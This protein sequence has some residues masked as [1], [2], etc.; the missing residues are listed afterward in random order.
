MYKCQWQKN[1]E[2]HWVSVFNNRNI[3]VCFDS[4][5]IECILQEVL[6]RIKEVLKKKII[7]NQL[8]SIYL[9]CKITIL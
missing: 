8:P 9:E 1:K 5:E 2:I 6:N 3:A 4:F 7:I